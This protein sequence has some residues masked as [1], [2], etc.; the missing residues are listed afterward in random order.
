MITHLGTEAALIRLYFVTRIQNISIQL[1]PY[2]SHV[3]YL[4]I[5]LVW[6]ERQSTS[7]DLCFQK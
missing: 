1:R 7:L 4:F 6:S 2:V 5:L 3:L